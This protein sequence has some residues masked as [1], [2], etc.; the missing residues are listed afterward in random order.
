M[1]TGKH[2]LH[3]ISWGEDMYTF[4]NYDTYEIAFW[5]ESI[6]TLLAD[7][8]WY[9]QENLPTSTTLLAHYDDRATITS[10]ISFNLEQ[11][12]PELFI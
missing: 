3:V 2:L 9:K 1:Q 11:D 12:H 5:K 4:I 7:L 10:L 6:P 8:H